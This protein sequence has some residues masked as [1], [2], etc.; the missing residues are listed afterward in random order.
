VSHST[1]YALR[2]ALLG[3][4][5]LFNGSLF[6][7]GVPGWSG[8][9]HGFKDFHGRMVAYTVSSGSVEVTAKVSVLEDLR[10]LP[11]RIFL[12]RMPLAGIRRLSKPSCWKR[13]SF[14]GTCCPTA[15][16]LRGPPS[17]MGRSKQVWTEVV[18]DRAGKIREMIP[19]ISHIDRLKDGKLGMRFP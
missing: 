11:A 8:Q 19:P 13:W 10:T 14:A 4:L 2:W 17:R 5:A 18:L 12:I 9:Y 3:Y 15:N 16:R 6:Y 1:Q 7:T